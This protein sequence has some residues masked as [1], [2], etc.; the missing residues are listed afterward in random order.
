M[1]YPFGIA[2]DS[3]GNVW[4]TNILG[5]V[6]ELSPAGLIIGTYSVGFYSVGIAIDQSGN[7]W[8]TNIYSNTVTELSPTVSGYNIYDSTTPG[9]PYTMIG[10][11]T[12][13]SYTKWV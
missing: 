13:T 9:G 2:I 4:V 1:S 6:T 11:T 10:F 3:S 8:I 7:V 5:T 12:T